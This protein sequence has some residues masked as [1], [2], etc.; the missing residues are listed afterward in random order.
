MHGPGESV[1]LIPTLRPQSETMVFYR[2]H[3]EAVGVTL[4]STKSI[5]MAYAQVALTFNDMKNV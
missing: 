5:L 4:S 3:S 2:N 1:L